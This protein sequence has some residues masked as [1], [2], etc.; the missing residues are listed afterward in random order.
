MK[1]FLICLFAM[2]LL[3]AHANESTE[4]AIRIKASSEV[5]VSGISSGGFFAAQLLVAYSNDIKGAALFASGPYYCTRG[6]ITTVVDCMTTGLEVFVEQLVLAAKSFELVGAIDP[7]SNLVNRRVY[8]Y[9]G[10]KDK[11]V[12]QDMVKKNQDFFANLGAYTHA[13]YDIGSEHAFPTDYFG[14]ACDKLGKPYINNCNFKGSKHA[15]EETMGVTLNP[16]VDFKETNMKSFSQKNYNPGLSSSFGSTGYIYIPD[17]CQTQEC[18]LHVAFHGCS[19]TIGDIGLDYVKNTG[20]LGLAESNN[21]IMLFPQVEKNHIYPYNPQGCWDWWGYS[22]EVPMPVSFTFPTN[23]GVQMKPIYRMI[24]D[25]QA[26]T[27]KVDK[28]FQFQG[29]EH[30]TYNTL[31]Y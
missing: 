10:S 9:S 13:D 21:I 12:W 4:E 18:P 11:I 26:G 2:L 24:K 6:V 15:L 27:F 3:F 30:L 8:L 17:G 5:T 23:E 29:V 31:K 16:Q 19:Q 25:I 7:L 20:F 28:E 22:E 14:N 1:S